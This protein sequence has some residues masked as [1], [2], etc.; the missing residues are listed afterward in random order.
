MIAIIMSYG[1]KFV[2]FIINEAANNNATENSHSEV[3]DYLI[4][5]LSP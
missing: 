3:Q 5:W 2:I 1:C 4:Q